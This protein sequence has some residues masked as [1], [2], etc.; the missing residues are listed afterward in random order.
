M[1]AFL[2][3]IE[4]EWMESERIP[5]EN[6]SFYDRQLETGISWVEHWHWNKIF[7]RTFIEL[8]NSNYRKKYFGIMKGLDPFF[9]FGS[10]KWF[11]R[12]FVIISIKF[13]IGLVPHPFFE[14]LDGTMEFGTNL[15]APTIEDYNKYKDTEIGIFSNGQNSK[16]QKQKNPE[17]WLKFVTLYYRLYLE[18]VYNIYAIVD[19]D[20]ET[21]PRYRI[22]RSLAIAP[23]QRIFLVEDI[24][25]PESKRV[26]KWSYDT[27]PTLRIWE[28]VRNTG[29]KIFEFSTKYRF[30]PNERVLLMERLTKLD[31]LD[32][33]Y[34]ILIDVLGQLQTLHQAG[35]VHADLKVDNIMKRNGLNGVEYFIIDYDDVSYQIIN[36]NPTTVQRNVFSIWFASQINGIGVVPTSYRNDLEELFYTIADFEKLKVRSKYKLEEP[37]FRDAM[38]LYMDGFTSNQI[39]KYTHTDEILNDA[40]LTQ[41][42][43]KI[44]VKYDRVPFKQIDH[45]SLIAFVQSRKSALQTQTKM[46]CDV[47]TSATGSVMDTIDQDGKKLAVCG[48]RCHLLANITEQRAEVEKYREATRAI[49]RIRGCFICGKQPQSKCPVCEIFYCSKTCRMKDKEHEIYCS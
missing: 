25:N 2:K 42:L 29:V 18:K 41:L 11:A 36:D 4:S 33:S 19:Q 38:A 47:C 45:S 26:V 3:T 40:Y 24:T 7:S 49:H 6:P 1:E 14:A 23:K 46:T 32:N 8:F 43:P 21:A 35:M 16:L 27:K 28:Q 37:R 30:S 48:Y 13:Y 15:E 22:V 17:K 10:K 5:Q 39:V 34:D 31:E 12:L 44:M 20:D 9:E